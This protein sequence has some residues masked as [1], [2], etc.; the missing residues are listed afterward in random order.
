M[1]TPDVSLGRWMFE[2][3]RRGPHRRALTFE[4]TTWTYAELQDRID[5]LAAGLR[6]RG[7]NHGD[8]VA[9]LGHNQPAFFETLFAAARLGAIFVPL[10]F[11]LTGPELTYIVNDAGAHTLVVDEVHRSVIDPIRGD[12]PCRQYLSADVAANAIA[13]AWRSGARYS[14]AAPATGRK[15]RRLSQGKESAMSQWS[16]VIGNDQSG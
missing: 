2:R 5:R 14:A 7:V 15:T 12:L 6:A 11:R 13:R 8:R 10:N 9:F 16:G 1:P 4:G 3:A